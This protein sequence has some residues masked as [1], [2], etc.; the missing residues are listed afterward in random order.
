VGVF[1]CWFLGIQLVCGWCCVG[2]AGAWRLRWVV[3]GGKVADG[4]C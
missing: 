3:G 2:S 1:W 4:H